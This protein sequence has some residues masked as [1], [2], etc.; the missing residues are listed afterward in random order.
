MSTSFKKKHSKFTFQSLIRLVIFAI[1]I[2]FLISFVSGQKINSPKIIDDTL[3]ID[4]KESNF[5]L[6]KTTEISNNIYQAIPENSRQQLENINQTPAMIFV[7]EKINYIK[8]QSQGFPQKQIK[9]IQKMIAKSIYE[10]A[11]RNIESN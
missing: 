11:V 1:L 8:E 5:I 6:G 7:Q 9:E 3:S 4:E 10:N 2:F